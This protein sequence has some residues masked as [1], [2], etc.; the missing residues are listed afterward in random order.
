MT[1]PSE[2]ALVLVGWD[3]RHTPLD[4]RE[5]LAFSPDRTREALARLTAEGVLTEGVIVSTCNRSELYG[6]S[7]RPEEAPAALTRFVAEFQSVSGAAI[8]AA[9]Y[10]SSGAMAVE[11]LFRVAS[12]LESLALGE[13]QILAQVRDAFRVASGAGA[14]RAILHRLFQKAFEA[15][16]RVRTETSLGGRPTSIPGVALELAGRLYEDLEKRAYL[17]LGAGETAAIFYDLLVARGATAIEVAN[18][19][20]ERAE[21]LCRRGGAARRWEERDARL[22]EADIVVTATSSPEPVVTASAVRSALA[23]RRGRPM[24]FLDL[25][26]PRNVEEEVAR[27]DNAFVYGVDDL[28]PIAERNRRERESE[29]PRAEEILREEVSDFLAW[30]GSLAV[31]PTLTALRQRFETLREREFDAALERLPGLA[32]ADRESVRRLAASLVK[33]LLRRPT[34]ALKDEEDPARRIER[35]ESIRHVFGLDEEP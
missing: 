19:T 30:Y 31:V 10:R 25:S 8:E 5:R 2:S 17:L 1:A 26:V 3:F 4:L 32:P 9:G 23:A 22:A 20:F 27:L 12:G 13:D 33:T 35:A 11:H 34:A 28:T 14:T 24:F 7:P 21:T 18:R 6:F 15:G 16:K 29:V